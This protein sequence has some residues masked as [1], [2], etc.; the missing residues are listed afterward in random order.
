MSRPRLFVELCAGSAAVSL[1]LVGGPHANPPIGYMGGKRG[2][3][4]AILGVLGLR[5]GIGAD[6]VWLNDAGPWGP[7]WRV[8]TTPGKA[9]EVAAIIRGWKDEEPRALWD[10]LKAEGW[11]ELTEA[12][13]AA[14]WTWLHEQSYGNKGPAAGMRGEK[15]VGIARS[16]TRDVSETDGRA[17]AAYLVERR[18]A[19]GMPRSWLDREMGTNGAAAWWEGV[20]ANSNGTGQLTLPRWPVYLRLKDVLG[21]DDRYDEIL[22]PTPG[23]WENPSTPAV[24]IASRVEAVARWLVCGA[25]A[26]VQGDPRTNYTKSRAEPRPVTETDT[27]GG[28]M[29]TIPGLA[30]RLSSWPTPVRAFH[31]SALD[32]P[33]PEDCEGVFCYIDPPYQDTTGYQHDL[34]REDVIT[35]ARRWSDAG[36]VVCISEA[37]PIEIEGWHH[38]EIT[39]ERKGQ[40]RTFSSQQREWLTLNREPAWRPSYQPS[41]FGPGSG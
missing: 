19:L 35:L 7:V 25:W 27:Y 1:R 40:K 28:G 4:R 18:A 14:R 37:V 17:F 34:P 13:E 5:Q 31:G 23:S 26:Y 30:S 38:V 3:A 36:A 32:V 39:S 24:E 10:R 15:A 8:L 20:G 12:G 11:G 6:E 9:E 16:I 2:Y 29:L 21:M 22:K 33:I 41:L